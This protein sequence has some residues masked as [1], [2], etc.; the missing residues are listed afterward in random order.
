MA[1][2][3][4]VKAHP[5]TG[6]QSKTL[7]VTDVFFNKYKEVNPTDTIEVL[8]LFDSYI[9][10]LDGTLLSAMYAL[11]GGT[12]FSALTA[13]QQK[14]MA[15]FSELTEQFL[16]ADKIVIANALWNLNIPTKLKAWFDA[17]NVA[18]KTF[19]YTENGPVPMTE[20]KKVV[21]I[22]SGGGNYDGADFS[23]QYVKAM[24]N[25]VGVMEHTLVPI[26]GIDHHPEQKEDIMAA[27]KAHAEKVAETF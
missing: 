2:V 21:H 9:P 19:R 1:N 4:F 26:E 16:A 7:A 11:G 17:I 22:Q 15:G 14:A 6:E 8:D 13:E 23:S 20:G 5:L 27:A 24:M 10:E 18:G 25:F 3:L 12:E